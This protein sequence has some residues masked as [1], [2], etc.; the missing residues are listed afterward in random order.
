MRGKWMTCRQSYHSRVHTV[1]DLLCGE[2]EVIDLKEMA[3]LS[4]SGDLPR[5]H[6]GRAA[7]ANVQRALTILDLRLRSQSCATKEGQPISRAASRSF[8]M[9]ANLIDN[10]VHLLL[11]MHRCLQR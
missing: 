8:L 6:D 2:T 10:Q 3:R 11:V 4:A 5:I 1:S 7:K 9:I